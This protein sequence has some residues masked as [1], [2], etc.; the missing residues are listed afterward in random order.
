M[1]RKSCL[2]R[3]SWVTV[4]LIAVGVGSGGTALAARPLVGGPAFPRLDRRLAAPAGQERGRRFHC[5]KSGAEYECYGPL[6]IRTAYQFDGLLREGKDGSGQTIVI[7]DAFQDPTLSRDLA[8]FDSAFK[9]ATPSSFQVVAPFGTTPFEPAD[10]NQV[11]WSAEIALDVEWAH[12]I[13]PGAKLV[14]ALAPNNSDR[15]LI[16]TERYVVEQNLGDVISMS[17]AET[18]GCD[19]VALTEEEHAVFKSA[20]NQG[21]TSVAGAGDFGSAELNCEET[22]FLPYPAVVTP[23]SDP[24]VTAVGGTNLIASLTTGQYES[25]SVWNEPEEKAAGGGGFSSLYAA[26]R[27]QK[28]V[29]GITSKRG[30]PDVTYSASA[31]HGVVVAWGSSGEPFEFWN[32]FGTSAGTP[33]WAGLTAIADQVAQRHLGNINP[34]LYAIGQGKRAGAAFH[35]IAVGNNAFESVPGYTAT[36]GWDAASGW[37]SPRAANL[38]AT[39]ASSRAESGG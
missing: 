12:A 39:L 28:N 31:H 29:N 37:G 1:W 24:N 26:P 32:F 7:I 27:Y 3:A 5:Q 30:I 17:Y 23:A 38:V 25:E 34:A 2:N 16:A 4:T 21:I 10:P 35:D 11:G 19:P 18:E 22:A 13:A 36:P 8:S 9:L 20:V 14:L 33:Q 15:A 6:Q